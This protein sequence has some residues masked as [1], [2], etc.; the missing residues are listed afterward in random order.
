M[1]HQKPLQ[2]GLTLLDKLL[3]GGLHLGSTTLL[4]G[5]PG[6]GKTTL[7][8]QIAA[9]VGMSLFACGEMRTGNLHHYCKRLGLSVGKLCTLG[10][11]QSGGD[12]K[13]MCALAE[14]S[15]A[16]LV[17]FDSLLSVYLDDVSGSAG[18]SRM[19]AAVT[20]Y[21]TEWALHKKICVI[22][23]G[24]RNRD[25]LMAP[26]SVEHLVSTVLEMD[27]YDNE[28]DLLGIASNRKGEPQDVSRL[29]VIDCTKNRYGE[30]NIYELFVLG[31]KGFAPYVS[32]LKK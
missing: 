17:V 29:R 23:V 8:L 26:K 4:H 5:E 14:K 19:I 25:G 6:I 12:I 13:K 31:D 24:H 9:H 1:K 30:N 2:T 3:G 11:E 16:K 10:I 22:I 27:C 32:K 15:E 21:L 7:L 28:N 18:N 20:N